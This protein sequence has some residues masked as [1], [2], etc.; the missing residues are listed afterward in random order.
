M[1]ARRA[2]VWPVLEACYG[3]ADA[4][5]WWSRWRV[6]FMACAELWGYGGGQHW[7][8]SH[9]RFGRRVDA[10]EGAGA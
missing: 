2:Q 10:G 3:A 9:Y 8:V 5:R 1:D 6:F 4:Q 7:W